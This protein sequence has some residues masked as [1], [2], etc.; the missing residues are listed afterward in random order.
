MGVQRLLGSGNA[1]SL[2]MG[3]R[4]SELQRVRNKKRRRCPGTDLSNCLSLRMLS[5]N[6]S[7][8]SLTPLLV[9]FSPSSWPSL[10]PCQTSKH[11]YTHISLQQRPQQQRRFELGTTNTGLPEG[12]QRIQQR[13]HAGTRECTHCNGSRMPAHIKR[14]TPNVI[15]RHSPVP[16][17]SMRTA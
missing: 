4:A 14:E 8:D 5:P 9:T 6:S 12:I 7:N 11:A 3:R 2:W 1:R 15:H 16:K 10:P 13:V 17:Q